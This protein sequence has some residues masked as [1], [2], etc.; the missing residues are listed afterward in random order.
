MA[1][2]PRKIFIVAIASVLIAGCTGGSLKTDHTLAQER[3]Q[4]YLAANSSLKPAIVRA[5]GRMEL[6]KDM[7]KAQ[8]IA[9]WGKPAYI[10]RYNAKTEQWFFGCG[11]PHSCESPDEDTDFPLLDEIFNSRAIFTD[12]KL[13][14]WTS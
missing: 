3:V 11:W 8:I 14:E 1:I 10:Q 5:I 2:F 6:H 9:A 4:S 12:G 7:T 13:S